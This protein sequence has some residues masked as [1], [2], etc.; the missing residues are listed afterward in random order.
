MESQ[1][2]T[3][4]LRRNTTSAVSLSDCSTLSDND[5]SPTAAL[6]HK[7]ARFV[8]GDGM[9]EWYASEGHAVT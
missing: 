6:G 4:H 8:H 5:K 9:G 7:K 3:W 1:V 2:R